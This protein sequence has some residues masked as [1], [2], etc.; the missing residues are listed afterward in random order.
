MSLT[1]QK[2]RW[3]DKKINLRDCSRIKGLLADSRLNTVCEEAGCPNISECFSRNEATFL[4]LGKTC[5]RS[6]SFCGI[7]KSLLPEEVDFKEPARIAQSVKK[8]NLKHV[9]ITSVTRDDLKDGGAAHF[10]QTIFCVRRICPGT[11]IEVLIPDFKLNESSLDVLIKARPE[12]IAHNLETVP[13]LYSLVRQ[14][15]DYHRSLEVLRFIKKKEKKIFT[16]SGIMLGLG[17]SHLEVLESLKDLRCVGCDFL[18]LGQ[19]LPPS[20]RHFP[21]QEYV[22]PLVFENYQR[23]AKGLGFLYVLSA[24]YVRSSYQAADYLEKCIF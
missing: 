11:T 13:R 20:L 16:K 10:A 18:S 9:V 22:N 24:P 6:C 2:P 15:A 5:T 4:I 7:D 23:E 12:I 21:V 3:L 14:G 1:L 8:L 17:E 19:Y